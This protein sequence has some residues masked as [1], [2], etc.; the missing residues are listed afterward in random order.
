MAMFRD[1]WFGYGMSNPTSGSNLGHSSADAGIIHQTSGY[2]GVR[3]ATYDR[4]TGVAE[5]VPL[6][7]QAGGGANC[8][9]DV[10][11]VTVAGKGG[12][13][14]QVPLVTGA[15]IRTDASVRTS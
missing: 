9:A 7:Y 1:C 6:L 12:T 10:G 14:A 2:V 4:A 5:S 11:D 3:G 13:W 8:A 15:N